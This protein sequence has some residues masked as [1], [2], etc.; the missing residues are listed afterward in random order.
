MGVLSVLKKSGGPANYAYFRT[1]PK[2][3]VR[4]NV[5][6]MLT[7]ING[8]VNLKTTVDQ[9]STSFESEFLLTCCQRWISLK[10]TGQR[11]ETN[12]G[13]HEVVQSCGSHG[14]KTPQ[15]S[16]GYQVMRSIP[17]IRWWIYVYI[18]HS[19]YR[20]IMIYTVSPIYIY[21]YICL[22]SKH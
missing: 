12:P 13:H 11:P 18:N 14:F 1:N 5:V 2:P 20:Y 22:Y 17:G 21:T 19:K 9:L 4:P 16:F 3:D 8:Q 10:G 7:L 15:I 6:Q